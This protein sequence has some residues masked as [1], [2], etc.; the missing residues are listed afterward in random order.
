MFA[1]S[2]PVNSPIVT[3]ISPHTSPASMQHIKD[4]KNCWL[5]HFCRYYYYNVLIISMLF[6]LLL[7]A[8]D[9]EVER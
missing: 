4:I 2:E 7:V 6:L 5:V 3:F 1:N 9:K 8:M